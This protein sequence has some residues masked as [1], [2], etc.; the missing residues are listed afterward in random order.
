VGLKFKL[1]Y[2]EKI[3]FS[4]HYGF[5]HFHLMQ[6]EVPPFEQIK[7]E[8]YKPAYLKA[9]E[10]QKAVIR[11]IVTSK[12][13]A[14]FENTIKELEYALNSAHTND[15]LQAINMEMAPLLSKHRD[16]INLNDTLFLRVK[17]VYENMDKFNLTDGTVA[18]RQGQ[19]E[20]D[21]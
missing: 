21:K 15:S 12:E 13:E 9:F 10:E 16:D 11:K 2:D 3:S 18:R 14:T 6:Q 17:S 1:N 19:T 7:P 8:H 20:K 4:Y 5:S